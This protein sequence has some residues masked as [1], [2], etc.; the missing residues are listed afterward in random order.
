MITFDLINRLGLIKGLLGEKALSRFKTGWAFFRVSRKI[1]IPEGLGDPYSLEAF[2]LSDEATI[3]CPLFVARMVELIPEFKK[4]QNNRVLEIG[5]GTGFQAAIL[6]KIGY[7]VTTI[8]RIAL[9]HKLAIR[10]YCYK[11]VWQCGYK[12]AWAI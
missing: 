1:Y 8:E 6:A 11:V 10:L 4:K 3:T 9:L 12:A 5:T 2:E 7:R